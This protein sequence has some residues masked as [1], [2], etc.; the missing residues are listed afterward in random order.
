MTR[1]ADPSLVP[2]I[3]FR[4]AALRDLP[5]PARWPME[6]HVRRFYQKAPITLPESADQGSETGQFVL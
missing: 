1:H 6:P 4:P 5:L 2:R 3:S